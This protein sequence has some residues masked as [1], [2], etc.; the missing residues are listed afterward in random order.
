ALPLLWVAPAAAQ[1]APVAVSYAYTGFPV[2]IPIQNANTLSFAAITVPDA[3]KMTKVTVKVLV[4][5][6]QVGDLNLYLYSPDGTRV[7][8]LERNCSAL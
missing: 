6:P 7:K 4:E 3:L 5:Y 1:T 2:Y 8:L